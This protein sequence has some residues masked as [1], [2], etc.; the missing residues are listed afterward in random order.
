MVWQFKGIFQLLTRRLDQK[1]DILLIPK[2]S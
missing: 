2:H 1:V